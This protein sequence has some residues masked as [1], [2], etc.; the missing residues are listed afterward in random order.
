MRLS[1]ILE[2]CARSERKLTRKVAQEA[3][4]D[5]LIENVKRPDNF[6]MVLALM[7]DRQATKML[8]DTIISAKV[9]I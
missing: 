2:W 9:G 3:L 8:T 1:E 7:P 6:T 4:T 5:P